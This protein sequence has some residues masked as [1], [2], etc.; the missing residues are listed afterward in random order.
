MAWGLRFGDGGCPDSCCDCGYYCSLHTEIA[1][2]FFFVLVIA[3]FTIMTAID[4]LVMMVLA[5]TFHRCWHC[6]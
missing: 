6:F 2:S 1:S 4:T 5:I 3:M